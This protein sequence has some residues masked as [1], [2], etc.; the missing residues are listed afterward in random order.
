M[1]RQRTYDEL[2]AYICKYD[3]NGKVQWVTHIDQTTKSVGSSDISLDSKGNIYIAGNFRQQLIIGKDT[4]KGEAEQDKY[5]GI[6]YNFTAQFNSSGE[7]NWGR[8][9]SLSGNY[10]IGIRVF[11]SVSEDLYWAGEYIYPSSDKN[12]ST[13]SRNAIVKI[14]NKGEIKWTKLLDASNWGFTNAAIDQLGNIFSTGSLF[15]NAIFDKDTIRQAKTPYD[16]VFLSKLADTTF[17]AN[18]TPNTVS[19][20][21]FHDK[22][23]NC[24]WDAGEEVVARQILKAEPGPYYTSSDSSGNYTLYVDKGTYTITQV[25]PADE[26]SRQIKQLCPIPSSL[27]SITFNSYGKDTSAFD[28]GNQISTQPLLKVEVAADR[29]RRCFRNTTTIRYKNEGYASAQNVQVK[30]NYPA[31]VIPIQASTPWTSKRDSLITFNIG[32]LEAGQS[33]IITL[34]DSVICGNEAIRGMTQCI[35]A[36]NYTSKQP[37]N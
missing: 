16:N 3:R 33:G 22:N 27:Y 9:L 17:V 36:M 24:R 29:R 11:A 21:I 19:G 6:R 12:S 32:T 37:I 10:N 26:I 15:T 18:P 14:S 25:L 5:T 31:Y 35:K 2:D 4:L 7:P 1:K 30:L 13:I 34:T 28:F 20:K 8:K 23:A